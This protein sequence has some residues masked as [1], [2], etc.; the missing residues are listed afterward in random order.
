MQPRR[1]KSTPGGVQ[2]RLDLYLKEHKQRDF[3]RAVD[4]NFLEDVIY[5]II[6]SDALVHDGYFDGRPFPTRSDY[7]EFV[8]EKI[9]R[10]ALPTRS[11]V[12]L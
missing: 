5:P 11:P 10:T 3:G 8:G 6:V 2:V 1:A 7:G 12:T 9:W 4:Q